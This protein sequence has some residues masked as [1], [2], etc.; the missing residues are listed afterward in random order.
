MNR[1][2]KIAIPIIAGVVAAGTGIGLVAA[3]SAGRDQAATYTP[4]DRYGTVATTSA[5]GDGTV[6]PNWCGGPGASG[7]MD[8]AFQATAQ[9]VAA[10]FGVTA[11]DL[12]A[13]LQSGKTLAA[14]ATE[15][16]VSQDNLVKTILGPMSEQ[17]DLMVKYGY[18]TREQADSMA[19]RMKTW[20][21]NL[22]TSKLTALDGAGFMGGMMGDMMG[23]MM[24]DRNTPSKSGI[25]QTPGAGWGGMMQ[26]GGMMGGGMGGMMGGW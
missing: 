7:M 9:R 26:G 20:A 6:Q 8:Q 3:Q 1:K 21:Q 2:T 22:T 13:Q 14:M 23:N 11:A 19:G 10:L 18:M 12:Q 17:M 4:R 16:G 25:G 24:G 15:K 5:T